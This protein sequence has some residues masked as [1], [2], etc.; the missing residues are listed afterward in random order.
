MQSTVGAGRIPVDLENGHDSLTRVF[1]FT[2]GFRVRVIA[3][4]Y[5]LGSRN[6]SGP[7]RRAAAFP[8][9][10]NIFPYNATYNSDDA[11]VHLWRMYAF[12]KANAGLR[13]MHVGILIRRPNAVSVRNLIGRKT[14]RS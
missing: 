13:L 9:R 12:V 11:V 4:P 7:D 2:E 10:V 3:S 14:S 8:P 5:Q 6:F 1:P